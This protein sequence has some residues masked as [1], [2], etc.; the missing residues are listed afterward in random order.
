MRGPTDLWTTAGAVP[1]RR[2]VVVVHGPE[3][4]EFLQGQLSQDV[5]ALAVGAS[6]P[7]LL[8][9]P[10]GK[11]DAWLRVTRLEDDRLALDVEDGAGEAVAARLRR[12]KLRTKAEL[13][14]GRWVGFAVRGVGEGQDIDAPE[15]ARVLPAA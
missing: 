8:L 3:A 10:T 15:G 13:E 14:Q 1:I 2:D 5:A 4:V 6:A 12:F 11:V 9:Q 7:A